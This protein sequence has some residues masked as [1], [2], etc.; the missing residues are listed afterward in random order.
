MKLTVEFPSVFVR[1]GGEAIKALA[2]GV[3]QL[4]YDQLD[5]FDHVT[6]AHP[7][8]GRRGGPYPANMPIIE[9]LTT[10]G[11]VAAVT[12]RIGL[13][14]EVLV[15]P[16]RQPALVAKQVGTIDLLSGGRVRL[17]VG[18]G[19][20]EGEYESLGVPFQERGRRMDE[21][22]A[23]LRAYW[24]E[25]AVTYQGRYY[26]A[27]AIAMEPKPRADRPGPP[28]WMGG[29]ADAML[30]RIGAVGDGWLAGGGE[31]P[32]SARA[33]IETI[34]RAA[35]AAGRDPASIGLQAQLGDPR[36]IDQMRERAARFAPLGF[37]W[38]AVNMTTLYQGGHRTVDAQ[39]E[40]L[41]RI[42]EQLL[43]E[44]G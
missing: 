36:D 35:E 22:L 5:M 7:L 4:G 41:G 33:R 17:G 43:A 9:A 37:T 27:R 23:L 13:G 3:E 16:Q 14:T 26:T 21:C 19:W 1:Q 34:H 40:A 12:E 31:T 30:Q 2:R 44:T 18:V 6:M 15:L 20:Q 32:E 24:S 8:E 11:Y 42:R 10:L 25:P 28:V 38:G 39:L 29:S